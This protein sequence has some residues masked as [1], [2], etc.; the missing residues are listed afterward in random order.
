MEERAEHVCII[1][2]EKKEKAYLSY[3][4]SYAT[5][6]SLKWFIPMHKMPSILSLS[7]R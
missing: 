7:I 6:A 4:N 5:L 2:E 3:P 1:C